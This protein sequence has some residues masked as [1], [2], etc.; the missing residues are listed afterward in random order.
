VQFLEHRVFG[1]QVLDGFLLL[2]I[3]P[4]CQNREEE[5]PRLE[6]EVHG[7][8]VIGKCVATAFTIRC[9]IGDSMGWACREAGN[10]SKA[11]GWSLYWMFRVPI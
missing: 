9:S 4:S 3:D 2:T 8:A 7:R 1:A 5:L 10:A 11:V 6:D